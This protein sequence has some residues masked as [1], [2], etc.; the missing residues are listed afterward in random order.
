MSSRIKRI[1]VALVGTGYEGRDRDIRR[2]ASEGSVLWVRREPS[3][4]HDPNAIAIDMEVPL[5]WGLWKP[6]RH[7]G[8]VARERAA[9]LAPRLDSGDMIVRRAYISNL[10][11]LDWKDFPDVTA[12]IEYVTPNRRD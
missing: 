4:R 2:F 11:G 1:Q 8:Y 12:T 5:L 7:I 6:R 10:Y 3:N 9:R